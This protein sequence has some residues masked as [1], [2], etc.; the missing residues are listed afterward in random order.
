MS[1]RKARPS[2]A[3]QC[4][5]STALPSEGPPLKTSTSS[6]ERKGSPGSTELEGPSSAAPEAEP[7][8]GS[9]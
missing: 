9:G 5:E 7:R 1:Q 8:A 3:S 2:P 6:K 4:Q